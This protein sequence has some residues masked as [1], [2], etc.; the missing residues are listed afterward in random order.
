MT[1]WWWSP[2]TTGRGRGGWPRPGLRESASALHGVC[3]GSTMP[4]AREGNLPFRGLRGSVLEGGVRVPALVYSPLLPASMRG[5]RSSSITAQLLSPGP[6]IPK[7][8]GQ[9]S[10]RSLG[11]SPPGWPSWPTWWTGRR[12]SW[13]WP[14]A[15]PGPPWTGWVPPPSTSAPGAPVAGGG[16]GGGGRQAPASPQPGYGRPERQLPGTSSTKANLVNTSVY[17]WPHPVVQH[18]EGPVEAGLGPGRAQDPLQV[19]LRQIYV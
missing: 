13:R 14:A 5:K 12:P 17:F 4:V 11:R 19:K 9:S 6:K 1:R 2:R 18:E 16:R 15:P 10:G 7:Y 3:G 8:A